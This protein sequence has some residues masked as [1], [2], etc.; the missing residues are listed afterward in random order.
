MAGPPYDGDN[1]VK[2]ALKVLGGVFLFVALVAAAGLTWLVLRK[3]AQRP[4]SPEKFASTPERLARGEY[5]THHVTDCLGCHSDHLPRFGFPVKPGTEGQGGFPFGKELGVP[6][7]VCAQNITPD[8]DTGLGRWSDGEIARAIR[9]GV[10]REGEALFPMMPYPHLRELSDDDVKSIVV[11]LRTLRPIR[12]QTPPRKIDF[13]VNLLIKFA[14]K[15]V[16]GAVAAPDRNDSVAYGRYLSRIAGCYECHTPHDEK[17]QL[18]AERAFAGGWE[19]RGPWGRNITSNL[20]PHSSTY[21]GQ[22][23][24]Q[25]FIDRFRSFAGMTAETAPVPPPGRNTVMPWLA[26]ARMTEEDLGAI[27]D[28]L[29]TVPPVENRVNA[30]PDAR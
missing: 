26:F 19:M 30:F 22:A 20:T 10:N 8:P 13:P 17:N 2:T 14:P 27:Y 28:Y 4:A 23:T 9:E 18:V 3:P 21:I 15:P 5:L 12:N 1:S 16:E 29:R 24:R 11:Y 6:G 25:E 7:V